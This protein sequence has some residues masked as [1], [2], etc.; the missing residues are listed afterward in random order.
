MNRKHD[1]E[2]DEKCSGRETLVKNDTKIASRSNRDIRRQKKSGIR[3]FRK[4]FM[5]IIEQKFSF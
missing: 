5:E 2:T 1:S 3:D 4:P